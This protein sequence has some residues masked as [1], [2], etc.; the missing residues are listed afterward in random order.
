MTVEKQLELKLKKVV[1]LRKGICLKLTSFYFTGMPDRLCLLPG[2]KIFFVELK[3][4]GK[5]PSAVQIWMHEKLKFLGFEVWTID[6]QSQFDEFVKRI[7]Q[8]C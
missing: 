2:A 3:S 7:D 1:I 4:T 5:K 8:K 6:R